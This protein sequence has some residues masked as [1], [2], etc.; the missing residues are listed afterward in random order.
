MIT[1]GQKFK[2]DYS[3][4]FPA[5]LLSTEL[6]W[7]DVVL[8]S[9]VMDEVENV[10]SWIQ[11]QNDIINTNNKVT[12]YSSIIILK[13]LKIPVIAKTNKIN[14]AESNNTLPIL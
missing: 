8:N 14:G 3:S 1:I 11:Y 5:K 4:D 12:I 2:P 10:N 9:V 6:K 7:N 13:I